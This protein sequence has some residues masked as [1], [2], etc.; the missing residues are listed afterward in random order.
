M[1]LLFGGW[2]GKVQHAE[3]F[4]HPRA[5]ALQESSGRATLLQETIQLGGMG[6]ALVQVNMEVSKNMVTTLATYMSRLL[7]TGDFQRTIQDEELKTCNCNY[8]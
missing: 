7:C 2:P 8:D 4:L 3:I 6:A 1:L 5:S